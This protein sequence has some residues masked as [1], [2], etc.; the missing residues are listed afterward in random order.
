PGLPAGC[1]SR[2]AFLKSPTNSFFF[3][4]TDTTGCPPPL[5][6]EHLE[7]DVPELGVPV[8]MGTAGP[9]L[10]K[11]LEAVTQ[12]VKQDG[13]GLGA[14]PVTLPGPRLRDATRALAGPPQR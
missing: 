9:G 10:A 14:D 12:F 4:S 11:G 1:H 5:D 13:Y 7:A 8:G 2:P 3:V 6:G